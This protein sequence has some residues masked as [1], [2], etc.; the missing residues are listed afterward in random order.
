MI[1]EN[2]E[3]HARPQRQAVARCLRKRP[4]ETE[5]GGAQ[6]TMGTSGGH[7]ILA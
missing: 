6:E 3:A 2:P 4:A 5:R 1:A 7:L